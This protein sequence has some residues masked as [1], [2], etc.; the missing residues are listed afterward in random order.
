MVLGRI[1]VVF[2]LGC[3]GP[4]V[5]VMDVEFVEAGS[6][7]SESGADSGPSVYGTGDGS[8]D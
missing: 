7:Y 6:E 8:D 3:W 4:C 1:D 5:W 2:V